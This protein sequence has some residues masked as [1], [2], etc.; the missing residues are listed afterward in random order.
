MSDDKKRE[1]WSK[2]E[3]IIRQF[4]LNRAPNETVYGVIAQEIEEIIPDAVT[5]TSGYKTVDYNSIY[6]AL[7]GTLM[8]KV[9]EL[10]E[11]VAQLEARV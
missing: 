10:E 1:I 6:G 5:T 9:K 8:S 3:D 7:I 4:T 2:A 11:K